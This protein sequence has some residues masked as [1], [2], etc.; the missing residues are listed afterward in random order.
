MAVLIFEVEITGHTEVEGGPK[1]INLALE[2]LRS[3]GEGQTGSVLVHGWN[4]ELS[5]ETD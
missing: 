3:W 5:V 1:P 2:A 4:H